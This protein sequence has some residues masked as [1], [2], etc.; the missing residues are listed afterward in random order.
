MENK[1]NIWLSLG[2]INHAIFLA[3]IFFGYVTSG[4]KFHGDN[5]GGVM[6]VYALSIFI[7]Q[8]LLELLVFAALIIILIINTLRSE[9]M[10]I[11]KKLVISF[12]ATLAFALTTLFVV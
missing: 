1:L 11:S 10:D 6:M 5:F 12:L 7:P 9:I 3:V 2:T 4:F 8:I